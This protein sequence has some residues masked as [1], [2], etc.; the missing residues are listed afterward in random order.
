MFFSSVAPVPVDLP[1]HFVSLDSFGVEELGIGLGQPRF[2]G[3]FA[4]SW[5]VR[6]RLEGSVE[7]GRLDLSWQAGSLPSAQPIRKMPR[8]LT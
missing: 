6:T 5:E 2:G 4:P 3:R 8:K 1:C 7:L